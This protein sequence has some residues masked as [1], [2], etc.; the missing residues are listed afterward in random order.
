MYSNASS[1]ITGILFVIKPDTDL[2]FLSK[3]TLFNKFESL[4]FILSATKLNNKIYSVKLVK[5][6]SFLDYSNN[7]LLLFQSLIV[8]LKFCSQKLKIEIM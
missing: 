7:N 5:S 4:L 2:Q 6:T 8:N 3:K 1:V